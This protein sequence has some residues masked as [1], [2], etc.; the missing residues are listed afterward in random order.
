MEDL[1][2]NLDRLMFLEDEADYILHGH[3]GGFDD[4]SL[5]RCVREG[6]FEICQGKKEQDS[7]YY[8]FNLT[9][10]KHP[11]KCRADRKYYQNEHAIC[12]NEA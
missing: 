12:Y 4:I 11:F 1:V 3:T 5:M 10:R 2:K 7:D 9:A 8:Y 6:A